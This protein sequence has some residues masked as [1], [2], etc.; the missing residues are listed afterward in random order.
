MHTIGYEQHD[1]SVNYVLLYDDSLEN[2]ITNVIYQN[3]SIHHLSGETL[4]KAANKQDYF[5]VVLKDEEDTRFRFLKQKDD[6]WIIRDYYGK[7]YHDITLSSVM[8]GG[9]RRQTRRMR[10]A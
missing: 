4:N 10:R 8:T 6:I 5:S 7:T 3:K 2:I 1:G 9:K